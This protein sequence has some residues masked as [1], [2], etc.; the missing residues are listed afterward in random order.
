MQVY[1][2]L[3]GAPRVEDAW[4][5]DEDGQARKSLLK[6]ATAL[7][8]V[9]AARN[10]LTVAANPDEARELGAAMAIWTVLDPSPSTLL[11]DVDEILLAV[12]GRNPSTP[13]DWDRLRAVGTLR[14]A[15]AGE[16][17]QR[18]ERHTALNSAAGMAAFSDGRF[19]NA[20]YGEAQALLD[21][22][23]KPRP[24]VAPTPPI[25]AHVRAG[26]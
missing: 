5:S 2:S 21:S 17:A 10:L 22:G 23:P 3:A 1:D 26:R 19:S 15:H 11:A 9:L 4:S 6:T 20:T 13:D 7:N 18:K 8:H 12:Q 25:G 16:A 14:L 24:E